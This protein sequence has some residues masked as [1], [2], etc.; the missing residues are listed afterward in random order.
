MSD[1]PEIIFAAVF[2]NYFDKWKKRG[3]WAIILLNKVIRR[4]YAD[5]NREQNSDT[6]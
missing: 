5:E 6:E 2:G 3:N 4:M 1:C